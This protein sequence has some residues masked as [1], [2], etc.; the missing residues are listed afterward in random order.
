MA[1]SGGY[2]RAFSVFVLSATLGV[3]GGSL[4]AA[5]AVQSD[6]STTPGSTTWSRDSKPKQKLTLAL[7]SPT[8][9]VSG[10]LVTLSG[11]APKSLN[12]KRM[13]LYR[14][15]GGGRMDQ[16]RRSAYRRR[17]VQREAIATGEETNSWQAVAKVKKGR[18]GHKRKKTYISGVVSH[19]M[20]SWYPL[21]MSTDAATATTTMDRSRRHRGRDVHLGDL[22]RLTG[23]STTGYE[24]EWNMSYK[25]LQSCTA[26]YGL[27]NDSATGSSA[28]FSVALDGVVQPLETKGLGPAS[29]LTIDVATRLRIKLEHDPSC[30]MVWTYKYPAFAAPQVLCSSNPF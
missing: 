12:G 28:A 20:Y 26:A 3:A 18:K 11:T 27:D 15:V 4:E 29:R 5:D 21:T 8:P 25:C 19:A 13:K 23:T 30:R 16:G 17:D 10:T 14:R 6:Q 22:R 2:R 7:A 1:F 9:I 24:A